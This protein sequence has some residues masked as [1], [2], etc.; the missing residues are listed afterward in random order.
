[1][2]CLSGESFLIRGSPLGSL[3][4][5]EQL[6]ANGKGPFPSNVLTRK[7]P[8]EHFFANQSIPTFPIG[9][10][11]YSTQSKTVLAKNRGKHLFIKRQTKKLRGV[12]R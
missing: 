7:L 2:L 12:L 4:Y 6:F 3:R 1:M 10:Q 9:T 8:L 11:D 5:L